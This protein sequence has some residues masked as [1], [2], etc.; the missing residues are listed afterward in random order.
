MTKELKFLIDI[1][2]EASKLITEELYI[3][4]NKIRVDLY[5]LFE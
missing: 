4:I 3:I 1:L 5:D 2:K